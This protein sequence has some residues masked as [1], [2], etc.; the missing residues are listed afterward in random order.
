[1]HDM[2][3]RGTTQLELA[4]SARAVGWGG[5]RD[6]AG[7][8]KKP[9]AGVPHCARPRH[10]ARHPVH[11]TV[12]VAREAASLR[13][14]AVFPS[15]RRALARASREAFRLVEFSVQRDHLH[16][17]VEAEDEEA[18]ARGMQGLG[19]RVA[20]A[21]NR[22]L[23]RRGRVWAERYHARALTSPRAVRNVLVYLLHN[24]RKHGVSRAWVDR[25]SSAPWFDGFLDDDLPTWSSRPR[26]PPA[27]D[28]IDE[29]PTAVARTWLASVGWR[30]LGLIALH[31]R[32]AHCTRC[33]R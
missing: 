20:R 6:R 2:G 32:P 7:R 15:V 14:D 8:R 16:L 10:A 12:R 13:A 27:T 17:L 1:M 28:E 23:G 11:V 24:A 26:A 29:R 22:V 5:R 18:L 9:G 30:R 19:V 3:T 21:T 4:F 25:C 33:T 31:D